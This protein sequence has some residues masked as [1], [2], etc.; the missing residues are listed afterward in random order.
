MMIG[1]LT[2]VIDNVPGSLRDSHRFTKFEGLL[3]RT[4]ANGFE[5]REVSANEANL[6]MQTWRPSRASA[7]C[8]LRA[9]Q[10]Q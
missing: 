8:R 4:A 7:P 6:S 10:E 5:M 9:L 2:N 3:E 1:T